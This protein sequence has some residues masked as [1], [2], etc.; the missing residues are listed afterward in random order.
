MTAGYRS[1]VKSL[2]AERSRDVLLVALGTT[3]GAVDATAFIALGHVF[4]SVITGNLVLLGVSVA[5]GDGRSALFSGCA[6]GAY[7]LGVLVAAPRRSRADG[8]PVWPLGASLV[9]S[10]D[11][12]LLIVFA[13][14]WELAGARPGRVTQ[15]LLLAVVAG[16]MGV[17]ST[18]VRRLGPI[19][20]T[21]L[22]GTLTGL[23]EAV[24]S[25]EWSSG[26]WRGL[27]IIV[28]AAIGAAGAALLIAHARGWLPLLV[29]APL[30][31]VILVSRRLIAGQSSSVSG[32]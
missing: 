11:L 2:P 8:D 26:H 14:G 12:A 4:A 21:Y 5:R 3:S 28:M 15:A 10:V 16:A 17:Q 18:A 22:T 25:G 27:G 6:L 23:L 9:L 20:T 31:T 24:R 7:A 29:L 19:S 30:A 1:P 32:R 13:I